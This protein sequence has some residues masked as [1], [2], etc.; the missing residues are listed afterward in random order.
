MTLRDRILYVRCLLKD[1]SPV[2]PARLL[3]VAVFIGGWSLLR[4][5]GCPAPQAFVWAAVLAQA[6]QVWHVLP[7]TARR[8]L[9]IGRA[10]SAAKWGV[11]AI[12]ALMAVQLWWAD[13]LFSQ[14]LISLYCA[15]Y[16]GI[17]LI[18]ARSASGALARTIAGP[19]AAEV[20][21][22]VHRRLFHLYAGLAIIV[23]AVNES[24]LALGTELGTRV[25]LLSLLPIVLHYI[26]QIALPMAVQQSGDRE[27]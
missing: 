4:L 15:A 26:F 13:P 17:M 7:L 20:P 10:S 12:L 8:P 25:A 21:S 22:C 18:T 9:A 3:M 2:S 23:L 14:R 6:A 11:A 16:A 1:L 27:T 24:L 5:A 19:D